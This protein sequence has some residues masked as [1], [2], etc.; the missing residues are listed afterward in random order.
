MRGVAKMLEYKQKRNNG[1][2]PFAGVY[3]LVGVC[4]CVFGEGGG[5]VSDT[6]CKCTTKSSFS[7]QITECVTKVKKCVA[8]LGL[9]SL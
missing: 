1:R 8:G 4:V 6:V 2:T 5:G 3:T 9:P 7:R